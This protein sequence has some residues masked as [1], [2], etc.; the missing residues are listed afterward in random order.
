MELR[1]T[2]ENKERVGKRM[3]VGIP[4][5]MVS[6]VVF[7]AS[8]SSKLKILHIFTVDSDSG[9]CMFWLVLWLH[10]KKIK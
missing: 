7:R 2:D 10:I 4:M 9:H 5:N 6:M 3:S 8:Q 1:C